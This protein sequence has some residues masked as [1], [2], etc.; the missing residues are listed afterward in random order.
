MEDVVVLL[1]GA[2]TQTQG[3]NK[4][5]IGLRRGNRKGIGSLTYHLG[6]LLMREEVWTLLYGTK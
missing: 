5:W 2:G 1:V 4:S 3:S 6:G